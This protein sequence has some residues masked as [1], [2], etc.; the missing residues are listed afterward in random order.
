M[1]VRMN[2]I[3][4]IQFT[5]SVSHSLSK[6]NMNVLESLPIINLLQEYSN[7]IHD[8]NFTYH[9][10]PF[11]RDAHGVYISE[12]EKKIHLQQLLKIQEKTGI[13]V[14]P[15]FNNIYL[16]N[17]KPTLNDFIKNFRFLYDNGIRSVSIPHLLWMKTGLIQKAFP[18]LKIKNTVLRRVRNAQE[19]W[20]FAEAGFDY[21]NI[22]R[23]LIRDFRNLSKIKKAQRVFEEKTGKYVITSILNGE[24]CPGNCPLIEE[25]HQHSLTYP[26]QESAFEKNTEVF[27]Y[28]QQFSCLATTDNSYQQLISVNLP[29]FREDLNEICQFFDVIKLPGRRASQSLIDGINTIKAFSDV[30]SNLVMPYDVVEFISKQKDLIGKVNE[31]RKKIKNCKFQC[32]DC[33]LCSKLYS[34]YLIRN[35]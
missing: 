4:K 6:Q 22:D 25:H 14:S 32:W 27:R 26:L 12:I 15:V 11:N 18:G 28:P 35:N 5:L 23:V 29:Q 9:M 21:I 30:N 1:G 33:D 20:N 10:D 24:G 19:F 16:S 2:N 3:E 34:F 31:W 17:S 7:K 8:I 13:S